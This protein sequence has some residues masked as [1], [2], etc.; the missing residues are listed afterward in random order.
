MPKKLHTATVAS[1]HPAYK[2]THV[3]REASVLQA[4]RLMRKAGASELLL[5]DKSGGGP[6]VFGTLTA[7]DIVTRVIAAGLDPNVLT[8]GDIAWSGTASN[9]N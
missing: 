9:P 3:D 5:I 7:N 6:F 2:L 4:S 8:T 1:G